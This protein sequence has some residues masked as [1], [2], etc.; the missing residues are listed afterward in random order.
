MLTSP[1]VINNNILSL[2]YST[3]ILT[4][5][6]FGWIHLVCTWLLVNTN[7]M[8]YFLLREC[9]SFQRDLKDFMK[10]DFY[11]DK[12]NFCQEKLEDTVSLNETVM[13]AFQ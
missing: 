13:L 12:E 4:I 10:E 1:E 3:L 7:L 2:L 6:Y 5:I 8:F 9:F 11:M